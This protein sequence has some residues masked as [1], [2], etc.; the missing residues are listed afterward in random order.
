MNRDNPDPKESRSRSS[1]PARTASPSP[2]RSRAQE[3]VG[4]LELEEIKSLSPEEIRRILHELRVYQVELEMQ[5]EDLRRTQKE[6]D[7]SRARYFDLYDLA[8]V[9]YCTVSQKG[10]ILEAN[11]TLSTLLGLA[12]SALVR[13]PFSRFIF[14]EDQNLFYLQRKQLFETG[15]PLGWELRMVRTDSV[16]FWAHLDA[17]V[18]QN[19]DGTSVVLLVISDVSARLAAEQMAQ[20]KEQSELEQRRL[21]TII[22][23]I[24]TAIAL[25]EAPTGRLLYLNRQGKALYGT[26]YVGLNPSDYLEKIKPRRP[27]ERP[28]LPEEMPASRSLKGREIQ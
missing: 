8:P 9:G 2:L 17:T 23:A 28:Y 7:A 26:D 16:P 25:L 18:V 27:D 14:K 15:Q 22:E 5:N 3:K 24:P 4:D 11:L 1:N 13:Q 6:L 20:Q 10:I 12:R 19:E 21:E